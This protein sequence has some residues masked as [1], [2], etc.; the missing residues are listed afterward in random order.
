MVFANFED[1]E[2]KF[3]IS[4]LPKKKKNHKRIHRIANESLLWPMRTYID[5][6]LSEDVR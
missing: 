1:F 4:W 6:N 2:S 3:V 5:L